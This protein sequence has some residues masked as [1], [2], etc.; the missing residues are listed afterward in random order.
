MGVKPISFTVRAPGHRPADDLPAAEP[1]DWLCRAADAFQVVVLCTSESPLD[2]QR[3]ELA[4]T[5]IPVPRTHFERLATRYLICECF[6]AI[7][8][9]GATC[10]PARPREFIALVRASRDDS[11]P[12]TGFSKLIKGLYRPAKAQNV[13]LAERIGRRIEKDYACRMTANR[14]AAEWHVTRTQLDRSFVQ[15]FGRRFHEHLTVVRLRHGLDLVTSGMKIEAAAAA[16]GYRSKK[17]FY[18]A[19]RLHTGL[20]PGQ[21]RRRRRSADSRLPSRDA[22]TGKR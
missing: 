5:Q 21:L 8:C 20:T 22:V 17:D 16:V 9:G 3:L 1:A 2:V 14:M 12:I 11:N 19:V 18:R 4:L 7:S 15:R 13:S 6:A 10:R